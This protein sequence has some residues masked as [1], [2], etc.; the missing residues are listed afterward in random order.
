VVGLAAYYLGEIGSDAQAF[1]KELDDLVANGNSIVRVYAAEASIKIRGPLPEYQLA[2]CHAAEEGESSA[3]VLAIVGLAQVGMKL[4]PH[5]AESLFLL[6]NDNDHDVAAQSMMTLALLRPVEPR[7]KDLV[8][9]I[10]NNQSHHL[11]ETARV[12]W[13]CINDQYVTQSQ[14]N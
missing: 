7:F 3:R 11:H 2:L 5:V 9:K 10:M 14:A 12:A 8:L 1:S 13:E 6:I 4:D